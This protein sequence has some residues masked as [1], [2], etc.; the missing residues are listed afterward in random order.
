MKKKIKDLTQDEIV[1]ICS[2]SSCKT[3]PLK[4][5]NKPIC[6]DKLSKYDDEEI[7]IKEEND[8]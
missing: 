4:A 7:E 1:N 2:N 5:P 8:R 3:C 6:K